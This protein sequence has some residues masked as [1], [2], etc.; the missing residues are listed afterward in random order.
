MAG[1]EN[2]RPRLSTTILKILVEGLFKDPIVSPRRI[3]SSVPDM[4]DPRLSE[5]ARTFVQ[6][7][8][9]RHRQTIVDVILH[10]V[11]SR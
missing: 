1:P 5:T 4:V 8:Y 10:Q 11:T 9:W 6:N 7:V 3:E 2:Q